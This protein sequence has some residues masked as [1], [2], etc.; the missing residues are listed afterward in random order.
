MRICNFS[1]YIIIPFIISFAL[2]DIASAQYP[3]TLEEL[4]AETAEKMEE[5]QRLSDEAWERAL[6]IV[7][8]QARE[9]RPYVPWANLPQQLPRAEIPAFPGAEGGGAFTQGGEAVIYMS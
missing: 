5:V 7:L 4:E 2:M 9:G 8:E 3:A 6:P 1:I